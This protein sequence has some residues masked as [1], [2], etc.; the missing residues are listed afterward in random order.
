MI[1]SGGLGLNDVPFQIVRTQD[2]IACFLSEGFYTYMRQYII[3]AY[4]VMS[5]LHYRNGTGKYVPLRHNTYI[6]LKDFKAYLGTVDLTS[7]Y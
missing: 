1:W 5:R 3:F 2:A 6:H 7:I 4:V